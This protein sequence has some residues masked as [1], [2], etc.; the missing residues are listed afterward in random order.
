MATDHNFKVKN[1]LTVQGET[2]VVN[3]T[4]DLSGTQVYIKRKDSSTNLMRWGEG[5][6][7]QSTYRW[8]IDQAFELVGNS[9]SG[10]KVRIK[11][12]D[13]SIE[14]LS[15]K[16][17][18]TEII[19]DSRNLSNIAS[20]SSG[21][22]ASTG[23]ISTTGQIEA[24][25]NIQLGGGYNLTWGGAYSSGKPTI[26]ANSNTLYFYP[27]GNVSGQRLYLNA[28][29]LVNAGSL[30]STDYI[31]TTSGGIFGKMSDEWQADNALRGGNFS[32]DIGNDTTVLKLFPASL[33]DESGNMRAAG[34]Y[35]TGIAFMH[36]DPNNSTWGTG[37]TGAQAWIGLKVESL[38]GQ[39]FS[40]F[41]IATNASSTAGTMP[42]ERFK[43]DKTGAATFTSTISSGAITSSGNITGAGLIIDG[44]T[45]VDKSGN[46][47]VFYDGSGN[48][49][50]YTGNTADN[51]N[52]YQSNHHRFRSDDAN[53]NFGEISAT[54]WH[55]GATSTP[56]RKLQVS[57]DALI[58]NT[59]DVVNSSADSLIRIAH[60]AGN[61]LDA[62]LQ[63]SGSANDITVEG[64]EIWYDNSAGDVHIAT[65]YDH[66]D[67]AIRFHTR[68][69]ASKSTS[70]ERFTI[71]GD[72][73]LLVA[74]G[75]DLTLWNS[76]ATSDGSVHLPRAG[77]ITFYG[78][79]SYAHSIV[80]RN[81]LGST[82][83]DIRINSYGAVY[84]N[85]D[86]NDNNTAG[87]SFGIG[88]H[89]GGTGT[90]SSFFFEVDGEDGAAIFSPLS[91][92]VIINEPS[93]DTDLQTTLRVGSE[94]GGL[95]LTSSN[96]IIGKGAYYNGAWIATATTGTSIDLTA[97][98]RITF[99]TFS[100]ATVGGS[101]AY[102]A[103]AY[104]SDSEI[105]GYGKLHVAGS[106]TAEDAIRTT[107][108]R[109]Q[110]GPQT[111]GAGI[112]FD[113][114][115]SAQEWFVG[116]Q[117]ADSTTL[118][119]YNSV[120]RMKLY[121]NGTLS[122]SSTIYVG[123]AEKSRFS[124][125]D[126]GGFGIN[127][128]TTSGT[129][130][131]SLTVYNNTSP[132][133]ELYR[134]GTVYVHKG[135]I[136][137]ATTQGTGKG[138]IHIDPNNT[139]AHA[140]GAITFGASD[141][142]NGTV[143]DAGIYVRSD[144]S[145]GTRMYLATTDSYAS[146]SK[147]SVFI[148]TNGDLDITRGKLKIGGTTVI[149]TSRELTNID[150]V[151]FRTHTASFYISPTNP[152]TLN[153]QHGSTSDDADL[154]INYRG[155]NDT[156]S[157]FRDF[158]IGDGKGT[159]L[160][161]VDGSTKAF[162]FQN[163]SYLDSSTADLR[164]N[165]PLNIATAAYEGL[166]VF[167]TDDGWHSGIR[168]H[169]DGDAEL[170]IW[171][172]HGTRGRIHITTAYD[173]EVADPSRPTNGIM[174]YGANGD[175]G[176]GNFSASTPAVG[177][178]LHVKSTSDYQL[179][180][181][182]DGTAWA[183]INFLDSGGNDSLW[184][185]G[186]SGTFALGGGGSS[187]DSSKKLHVHG[188][189][190]VGNGYAAT[191]SGANNLR[192]E[193]RIETASY[194]AVPANS[195]YQKIRLYGNDSSYA[196]GMVASQTYG[197]LSDWAM[198]FMFNNQDTRGFK[199]MDAAHSTATGAMALTTNGKLTVA[200]SLRLGYGESDTTTPGAAYTLDVSGAAQTTGRFYGIGGLLRSNSRI[201]TSQIAPMGHFS[202]GDQVFALD[203]TWTDAELQSYFNS[204]N[205]SWTA[206]STAPG[207]YAVYINGNVNVGGVYTSG[208]PYIPV[209]E[210]D[211][212][213]MECWVK[214]AGTGQT[215]YM[216]SNEFNENFGSLGGNPG[217]YGYWV[218]SNTNPG[219]SW[220]KVTGYIRGFDANTTGYFENGTKYW[221]PM[222][223]FNYGAGSGTRACY[224]SG[225]K[226][227]RVRHKGERT[228][229]DDMTI[230]SRLILNNTVTNTLTLNGNGAGISFSGGNNRIFF[231]GFR[232]MEGAT[233]G[234]N[235]QIGETYS[236][237]TLQ[238]SNTTLKSGAK[239][240]FN[241]T[242]NY[243]IGAGGHNLNSGYFDTLESGS[244]TDAL[245]LVYYQG[246]GVNIGSGASKY[247]NASTLGATTSSTPST[248]GTDGRYTAN[249]LQF[250]GNNNGKE[251][252]SAQISAG[253][254]QSNSLNF[255]GM[256]S[257]TGSGDRRMD[258]WVEGKA[259]FRG[260]VVA[261]GNVT[262]YGSA[263]DERLKTNI[264]KI[265][266]PIAKLQS[267]SGYTFDWNENAPEDRQ[268]L[269]EYG[270]IAQEVEKAGLNELVFE[271]ERPV[272]QTG[273]DDTPPEQWKA[274]HYEKFVPILIEAIKEQQQKIEKLEELVEKLISEK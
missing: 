41:V 235:L 158:R 109:L 75:K 140:G 185:Y 270:V 3:H 145:Y 87:A 82:V 206:D 182:G 220:T 259:Y 250:G 52:Y 108:G 157:N 231:G 168:Q 205:V 72:G 22:I 71:T 48:P 76:S 237:I 9:G 5:T 131:S 167:G 239:L 160:L 15:Y 142:S 112:W 247:L 183:G 134:D 155:Y 64:A 117:N 73:N 57:G 192:V 269:T 230:N 163:G 218:M 162:E 114:S 242:S 208:F 8:R 96:A 233:N 60:G 59:L 70:N 28:T 58:T 128:G 257:G 219:T 25:T 225:W 54:G 92:M 97:N 184:Y 21:A 33:N 211:L 16:I 226:V 181:D 153:A 236:L 39:E 49:A 125:D 27:T 43:I 161:F 7:G 98:D 30:I 95:Y 61:T 81:T 165:T 263:S 190:T 156:F 227:I 262:A 209:D 138:S 135:Q 6:S 170:R 42:V 191:A 115:S 196:I 85:L 180:L 251:T 124:S 2:L 240:Y 141:H 119:F 243:G 88:R 197:G 17:G 14:G 20:I 74:D 65:T 11:S 212:F 80:S 77:G 32:A 40:S 234:S 201:S 130:T 217:S 103:R 122:T 245:E 176:I 265:E 51:R 107:N 133:I 56:S 26:A 179:R 111:S 186:A 154:W 91:D 120:D 195:D 137:D 266:N 166:I 89:G 204:T 148:D 113:R 123:L 29:S 268:G 187:S 202:D 1:G 37:Y 44:N 79:T 215:H 224:I 232:A 46:Y 241:G 45:A 121:A 272:N 222:A 127:Y 189:M 4:G 139:N 36:L 106:N 221:T 110:L 100:G 10:D 255:V 31:R 172:K 175:V 260:D 152:N 194:L 223:L 78:D 214:N 144:G 143:A 151:K 86:S 38:P 249:G 203:P 228:F 178:R 18:S 126:N 102:G 174:V 216:G 47:M 118:R 254:H 198:T 83:D 147:T 94:A 23:T 35:S 213:Y 53:T 246:P 238:A 62:I 67:A 19:D 13:G 34:D 171:H 84:I 93:V 129:A 210:D 244:S 66:A 271:Y 101:A 90:M 258:F 24:G 99:N 149:N 264:V 229:D 50:L 55:I 207:G 256:S 177:A 159:G 63:F 12:S 252:N 132:T 164:V 248:P 274:V 267:I 173:G 193:G 116:L 273:G 261:T 104:I 146:G 253:E 105:Y 68:T 69:A 169:D 199:W 188:G 150:L 136:W 200:H